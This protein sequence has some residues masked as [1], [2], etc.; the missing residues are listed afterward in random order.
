MDIQATI[1]FYSNIRTKKW[2]GIIRIESN[3][4]SNTRI[5][6]IQ[7][8]MPCLQVAVIDS[9]LESLEA[10]LTISSLRTVKANS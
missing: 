9:L 1:Q 10:L 4:N 5:D 2:P 8:A 7:C 3:S 6:S